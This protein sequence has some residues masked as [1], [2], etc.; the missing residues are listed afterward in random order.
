MRD[1]NIPIGGVIAE[2]H[3]PGLLASV[4]TRISRGARIR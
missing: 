3:L 1:A 2:P 4:L